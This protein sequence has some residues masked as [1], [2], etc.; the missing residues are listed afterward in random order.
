MPD[1]V[2]GILGILAAVLAVVA[3][4]ACEK[5]SA[6]TAGQAKPSDQPIDMTTWKPDPALPKPDI[7]AVVEIVKEPVRKKVSMKV[8]A[9][10]AHGLTVHEV[11]FKL[12]YR[13][14]NPDTKQYDYPPNLF[15]PKMIPKLDKGKFVFTTP[16]VEPHLKDK[17][18]EGEND[19][20]EVEI[21]QYG[22]YFK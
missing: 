14:L 12:K 3:W 4:P 20:W 15:T 2:S 6:G 21:V 7:K 1:R 5:Q 17:A 8:T 16:I 9:T 19:N 22:A 18:W 13:V 11:H 10:E